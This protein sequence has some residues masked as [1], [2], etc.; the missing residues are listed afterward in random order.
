M[1]LNI[2]GIKYM[3]NN[4]KNNTLFYFLKKWFIQIY[5]KF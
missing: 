1:N 2:R 4:N 5:K 3:N